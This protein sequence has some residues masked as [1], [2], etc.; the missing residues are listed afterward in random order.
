MRTA[1]LCRV[2]AVAIATFCVAGCGTGRHNPAD[3]QAVS[4]AS[5]EPGSDAAPTN[6]ASFRLLAADPLARFAILQALI[7]QSGNRCSVV[8]K[9]VLEGGLDGTDE[10]RASCIDTG[11]W[12]VWFKP[13]S[14][15]D[16]AHCSN[17]K[18]A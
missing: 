2:A 5:R 12:Q 18:C 14:A 7:V 13:D 8:T 10:W 4:Y 9:G 16:V 6:D 11:A 17:A 15:P 1:S 3:E